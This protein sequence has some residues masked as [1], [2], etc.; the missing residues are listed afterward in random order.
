[1]ISV[2]SFGVQVVGVEIEGVSIRGWGSRLKVMV[3]GLG[4]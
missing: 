3:E 2:A 4:V 1:L